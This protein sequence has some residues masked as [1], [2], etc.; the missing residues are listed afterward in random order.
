MNDV[1]N[2]FQ[3]LVA[4]ENQDW[5]RG[6]LSQDSK[7]RRGERT[8]LDVALDFPDLFEQGPY[9][10]ILYKVI[11]RSENAFAQ[12]LA[13]D[14]RRNISRFDRFETFWQAR[15][16]ADKERARI[17]WFQPNWPGRLKP[18]PALVRMPLPL[19]SPALHPT[20]ALTGAMVLIRALGS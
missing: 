8:R 11:R 4:P 10:H 19:R 6:V 18:T 3:F 1:T 7:L 12:E 9:D 15:E 16:R 20:A 5:A 14:L 2:R 13:A 17:P